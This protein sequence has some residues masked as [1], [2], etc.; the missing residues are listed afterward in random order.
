MR[1]DGRTD[2]NA[3]VTIDE[4][5]WARCQGSCKV[6][7]IDN[8]MSKSFQEL[9]LYS[10]RNA[11]RSLADTG[12]VRHPSLPIPRPSLLSDSSAHSQLQASPQTQKPPREN[13][14]RTTSHRSTHSRTRCVH[15]AEC[16]RRRLL[17]PRLT[18]ARVVRSRAIARSQSTS[19]RCRPSCT[20]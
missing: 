19:S 9:A 18:R 16:N 12:P 1:L 20:G 15:C 5:T 7:M 11:V 17:L 3:I 6:C 2:D 8:L 10:L 4:F 13:R 14:Y